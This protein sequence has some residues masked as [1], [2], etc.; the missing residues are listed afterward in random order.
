[1]IRG[2]RSWRRNE[3]LVAL[4]FIA[5]A[6]A[7][8]V[9]LRIAP[10][11]SALA[12]SLYSQTILAGIAP[13]FVGFAN[14]WNLITSAD[15]RK[16]LEVTVVYCAIAVPIETAV[17]L[18]VAVLI[19]ERIVGRGLVRFMVF[20]PASVPVAVAALLW[21]VAY[22]PDGPLNAILG[23]LGLPSQPFLT[24]TG[25][26]LPAIMVVTGWIGVGFWMVFLIAGLHDIP[27]EYI[28][29]AA[30][31]GA[32]WFRRFFYVVLPLMRRP[33]AFVVVADTVAHFLFFAPVQILT[34]GGPQ[35]S[36]NLVMFDV[37]TNAF[38]VQDKPTASA[39][40]VILLIVMV[41]IVA[42]QFRLLGAASRD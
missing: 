12:T 40:V 21:S 3:A 4:C 8:L 31:D 39:E 6:L 35:L 42:G 19:T 29:A 22:R 14:Y 23:A 5:P 28:E 10:A 27:T 38:T 41:V 9:L 36:T 1:M 25:Q 15:F 16:S 7:S 33:I 11:V 37:Y 13:R 20:I 30:L 34:G 18:L 32:G 2:L 17:A 24:S 26:A